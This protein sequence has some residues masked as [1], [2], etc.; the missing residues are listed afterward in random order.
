M[1]I[2]SVK[3][4][5]DLLYHK[6]LIP[7]LLVD[8]QGK[9]LYPDNSWEIKKPIQQFLKPTTTQKIQLYNMGNYLFA[10]FRFEINQQFFYMVAGPC[11]AIGSKE[12]SCTFLGHEYHHK[13]HYSK[14]DKYS[15]EEF[16]HLLHTI[17]TQE[18]IDKKN[19]CWFYQ[20]EKDKKSLQTDIN[21]ENNLYDRRVH[22]TTFDSYHFELRYIDY[23]KRNE[24]EK[25]T[26]IFNKMKE[27]YKV[28]LSPFEL[29]GLKLKFAA[30]VAIVT[31]MAIEEG[32]P[33]NQAFGLSDSLIQ[34]LVHIHSAEECLQYIKEATF[35]FMELLHN[36]PLAHKSLLVKTIVN[37]I[38]GHLYERITVDELAVIAQK[39]KTHICSQFKKE[40][41][42]TIH[43]FIQEKKIDEAKHLLLFT[44]YSCEKISNLL[45]F[46]SQSH[47]IQVFKKI[48]GSTPK[49]YKDIHYAHSII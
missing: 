11:G 48:S 41:G 45:A 28:A 16:V 21:L 2:D 42:K 44:D 22:E 24:P 13:I 27:T 19:F 43:T 46:S 10:Y 4:V 35:R 39:H 3:H 37:H 40:M 12:N 26:W 33:I 1:K 17:L 8:E 6:Y 29:E 32:V 5:M 15:F 47:F 23:I 36:Y 18:T 20:N 9:L 34:G 14:E 30:F 31:R 7:M 49:E 38:D 25:V